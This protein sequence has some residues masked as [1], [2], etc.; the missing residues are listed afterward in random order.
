[1]WRR[2]GNW[3]HGK[4]T[5]GVLGLVLLSVLKFFT[6][7]LDSFLAVPTDYAVGLDGIIDVN[8]LMLL[9]RPKETLKM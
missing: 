8:V 9:E 4:M 3:C 5:C 6:F 1:M 7:P 2:K